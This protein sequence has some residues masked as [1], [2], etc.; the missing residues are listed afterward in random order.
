M[1]HWEVRIQGYRSHTYKHSD[2]L[3]YPEPVHKKRINVVLV[4]DNLES[5]D[6]EVTTIGYQMV[7]VKLG[8][9][10]LIV[11]NVYYPPKSTIHGGEK[12]KYTDPRT[13]L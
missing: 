8:R 9:E 6:L 5:E 1:R 13:V 7:L 4:K 12:Y 3:K 11:C 2:S 10:E